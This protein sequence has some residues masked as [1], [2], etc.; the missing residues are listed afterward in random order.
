MKVKFSN[1]KIQYGTAKNLLNRELAWDKFGV[2]AGKYGIDFVNFEGDELVLDAGSGTGR[3]VAII[4]QRL[5]KGGKIFAVDISQALLSIACQRS[6]NSITKPLC[7]I[8]SIESLPFSTEQFDVVVAKHV[9]KLI[10]KIN[11]DESGTLQKMKQEMLRYQKFNSAILKINNQSK[12][13][14]PKI[15]IKEYAKYLLQEGTRDEKREILNCLK[16]E[17]YLRD[18]KIILKK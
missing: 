2:G 6:C 8:A 10:D 12:I 1:P 11:F 16:T 14:T 9:L 13:K 3:D 5:S 18:Q 17:L 7:T 4:S 15:N